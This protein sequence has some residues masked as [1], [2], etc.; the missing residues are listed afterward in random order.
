MTDEYCKLY[1]DTSFD[2]DEMESIFALGF[3]EC[4]SIPGVEFS[5][6]ENDKHIEDVEITSSTHPVD[7]ARYYAEIDSDP[8][9]A[10]RKDDFN[11]SI[12][13]LVIWLRLRC[14]FVVAACDFEDYIVEV[15]GWNWTTEH[16][17]PPAR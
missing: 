5:L 16:P 13:D 2:H 3:K 9:D 15:T 6:L 17:L 14:D 1:I 7:R 11:L 8:A 12:S 4:I 10:I